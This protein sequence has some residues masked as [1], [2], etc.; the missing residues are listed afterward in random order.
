MRFNFEKAIQALQ[1]QFVVTDA[2]SQIE[3]VGSSGAGPCI[4]ILIQGTT[5]SGI[6]VASAG[7]LSVGENPLS[8]NK[9]VDNIGAK[10]VSL[11]ALI[12]GYSTPDEEI[13]KELLDVIKQHDPEKLITDLGNGTTSAALHVRSGTIEKHVHF[14]APCVGHKSANTALILASLVTQI[15]LFSHLDT[16]QQKA[17]LSLTLDGR[18]ETDVARVEH[19][20]K[21]YKQTDKNTSNL[22]VNSF[23][24]GITI[25]LDRARTRTWQLYAENLLTDR[26]PPAS[27]RHDRA[28]IV[29]SDSISVRHAPTAK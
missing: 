13:V 18:K 23:V 29:Y 27:S 22:T 26:T 15:N 24:F 5:A 16:R 10:T 20:I 11:V 17:M 8:I 6:Q 28:L 7:H 9:M 2:D 12:S 14:P 4:I 19:L 3:W 1:G 25:L 21:E